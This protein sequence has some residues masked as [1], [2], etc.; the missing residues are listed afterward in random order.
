[1]SGTR[2]SR[3]RSVCFEAAEAA[4]WLRS[5]EQIAQQVTFVEDLPVALLVCSIGNGNTV[6]YSI[7]L[8]DGE[9]DALDDYWN[10]PGALR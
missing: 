6:G 4:E 8:S 1:M 10:P 5:R 2:Q 7:P 3:P 9:M